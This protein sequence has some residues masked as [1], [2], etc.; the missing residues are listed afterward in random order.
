MPRRYNF[1]ATDEIDI[2]SRKFGFRRFSEGH[3]VSNIIRKG[4]LDTN[5]NYPF[6]FWRS[7]FLWCE[8]TRKENCP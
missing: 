6:N 5:I 7:L 1:A 2:L 3:E 8:N 4:F